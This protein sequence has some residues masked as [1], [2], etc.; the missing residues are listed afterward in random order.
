MGN[1]SAMIYYEGYI[2]SLQGKIIHILSLDD[3]PEMDIYYNLKHRI[4]DEMKNTNMSQ[5]M[6]SIDLT[7]SE[8]EVM[9]TMK[10][11]C[12]CTW[13]PNWSIKYGQFL[14]AELR[15]NMYDC[16]LS[17]YPA[18]GTL[19]RVVLTIFWDNPES[20]LKSGAKSI[21]LM[22]SLIKTF[23]QLNH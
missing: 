12:Y 21:S 17:A 4:I 22:K 3:S 6:M 15:S 11:S 19:E 13:L 7:P 14:E 18:T 8:I 5:G 16:T 10:K 1:F 9:V 20:M 2:S 23:E